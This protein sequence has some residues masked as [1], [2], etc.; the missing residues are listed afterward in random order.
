MPDR[1]ENILRQVA[2]VL[3]QITAAIDRMGVVVGK[4]E[5][6]IDNA[7]AIQKAYE[8][9]AHSHETVAAQTLKKVEQTVA[10]VAAKAVQSPPGE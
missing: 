2:D 6:M 3:A 7:A 8:T 5:T 1:P 10:E 9:L 4:T